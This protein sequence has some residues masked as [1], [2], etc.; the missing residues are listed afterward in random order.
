[1]KLPQVQGID[2]GIIDQAH[3][4]STASVKTIFF[5]CSVQLFTTV[6]LNTALSPTKTV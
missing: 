6:I 3:H 5:K 1:V 2:P 4:G